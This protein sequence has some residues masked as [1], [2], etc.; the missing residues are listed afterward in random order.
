MGNNTITMA[1]SGAV[2]LILKK[3]P[4]KKIKCIVTVRY[5]DFTATAKGTHMAY[6]MPV[7]TYIVVQV[8]YVDAHGNPATVDGAVAW[9]SSNDTV[10]TVAVDAQDSTKC[11]V[12][13]AG[14]I[15]STQVTATADADLGQGV[16]EL[17]T[18][19]DITTIA[20]E[21]VAGT[22]NVLSPPTPVGK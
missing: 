3:K 4:K 20:G 2:E 14:A 6:T 19:L 7:D 1:I 13:S 21:A 9:N 8:A 18:L 11:T 16:R 5:R 12:T 22:I 10:A 15:G 17:T